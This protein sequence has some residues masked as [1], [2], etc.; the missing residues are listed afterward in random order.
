MIRSMTHTAPHFFHDRRARRR[1]N[2]RF[3]HV[4]RCGRLRRFQRFLP[5]RISGIRFV[6]GRHVE[7]YRSDRCGRE[8]QLGLRGCERRRNG[9]VFR[10][11]VVL[12]EL[13]G[14]S[15]RSFGKPFG[16]VYHR[17][18]RSGRKRSFPGRLRHVDGRRRLDRARLEIHRLYHLDQLYQRIRKRKRRRLMAGLR[19][20]RR[21]SQRSARRMRYPM[22][23]FQSHTFPLHEGE[24]VLF[25]SQCELLIG[26]L[27]ER[28]RG[29]RFL[30]RACHF[31]QYGKLLPRMVRGRNER[32]L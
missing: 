26:R 11:Q 23:K 12:P 25:A 17:S 22:E 30:R 28:D 10:V 7:R 2:A 13:F 9:F 5:V 19:G 21:L 20:K 8:V 27:S 15:Y 24:N 6:P 3:F 29:H 18:G 16:N 31:V 14:H 1:R 32:R 4:S